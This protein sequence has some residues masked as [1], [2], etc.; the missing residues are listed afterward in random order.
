MREDVENFI[1]EDYK[2]KGI[3][4][5]H[6][7]EP[8]K[9]DSE[10]EILY[11]YFKY[12]LRKKLS[13]VMKKHL[14]SGTKLYA[15]L[16]RLPEYCTIFTGY[17][18]ETLSAYD[19]YLYMVETDYEDFIV[20]LFSELPTTSTFFTISDKLFI[21]KELYIPLLLNELLNK[22]IIKSKARSITEFYWAK[23]L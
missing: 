21:Y 19:P 22:E 13:P 16:E 9:W 11:R 1:P 3:I 18:P 7:D 23:D 6:F 5:T 14:I 2:P 8:V 10:D 12:N 20:D 15:W 17:Y 4:K